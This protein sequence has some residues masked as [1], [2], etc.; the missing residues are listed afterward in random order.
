MRTILQT[1][2]LVAAMMI[3]GCGGVDDAPPTVS[4]SGEVTFNGE[5]LPSGE[6]IFRPSDKGSRSDAAQIKDGKYTIEK[7]T[8]GAKRVEITAMREDKSAGVQTLETG[9]SG[10]ALQ[11][12]IPAEYNDKSTLT[13]DVKE[14]DGQTFNFPLKGK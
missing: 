14:E 9:E 12:Y 10:P 8:L 5:P 7:C 1:T 2:G 11:Q 3:I 13:A 6:I 4:I